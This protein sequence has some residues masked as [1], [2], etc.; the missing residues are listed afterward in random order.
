MKTTACIE[1]FGKILTLWSSIL[2]C[3]YD[4]TEQHL[5]ARV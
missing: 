1:I 5:P 4:G 2:G 3:I